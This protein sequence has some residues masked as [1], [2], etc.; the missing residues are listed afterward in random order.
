M[1][2]RKYAVCFAVAEFYMYTHAHK[3][4]FLISFGSTL[5][6]DPAVPAEV[7]G[8]LPAQ[9]GAVRS[10]PLVLQGQ[11]A[12]RARGVGVFAQRDAA[13][14]LVYSLEGRLL[15]HRRPPLEIVELESARARSW[16]SV[17]HAHVHERHA[18]ARVAA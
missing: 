17:L 1:I 4:F 10:A 3:S 18:D 16:N 2:H 6:D 15:C 5:R 12:R 14:A 8:V 13:S 7:I 11:H 9:L